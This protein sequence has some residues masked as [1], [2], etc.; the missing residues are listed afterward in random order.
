[1][2]GGPQNVAGGTRRF[3][4]P[5]ISP[6]GE[7]VAFRLA[8]G[9][10]DLYIA[11]PDGTDLRQLTDDPFNDRAPS[12]MPDSRHIVFYSDRS[13]RYE[14]WRIAV[15]GSGLEQ[16]TLTTGDSWWWPQ[17]APSGEMVSVANQGGTAIF[18]LAGSLPTEE[19]EILPNP[20]GEDRVFWGRSWSPDGSRI[21]GQ[22]QTEAGE[23]LEIA[24]YSLESQSYSTLYL[25]ESDEDFGTPHWLGDGRHVIFDCDD[26]LIAIDVES[27][28]AREIWDSASGTNNFTASA[29][30]RTL[31]YA[32]ST[33]ES[34]LWLA[35]L[36]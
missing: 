21:V 35:E 31:V 12:W 11:R 34:D 10:E 4:E 17:V 36:E 16:L 26:R 15:D 1:M 28:E 22:V 29:D 19:L 25:N 3:I 23:E 33:T 7:R 27:G 14:V 6:D 5:S 32:S 8:G 20:E 24:A 18:S 13:G 2:V 9:Q 30:G